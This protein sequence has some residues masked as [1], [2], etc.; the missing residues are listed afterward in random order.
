MIRSETGLYRRAGP[1]RPA[2]LRDQ[3][4]L[5]SCCSGTCLPLLKE[6]AI[7]LVSLVRGPLLAAIAVQ[8]VGSGVAG[9]LRGGVG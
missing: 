5:V 1:R 6:S 2:P 9:W 3:R 8:P 7:N 4:L